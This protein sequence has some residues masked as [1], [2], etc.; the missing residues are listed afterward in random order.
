MTT[1]NSV[2]VVI[3]SKIGT[4]HPTFNG[5]VTGV[6]FIASRTSTPAL[7]DVPQGKV[8]LL[9]LYTR[10]LNVPVVD[11]WGNSIGDLYAGAV[12]TENDVDIGV[13]LTSTSTYPDIVGP[14]IDRDYPLIT[15]RDPNDPVVKTWLTDSPTPLSQGGTSTQNISVKVD[16]FALNPAVVNRTFT[17]TPPNTLVIT[18]P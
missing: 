7:P 8:E 3:P 17:A 9:T 1:T 13:T 10:T 15:F 16:G 18:W 11:K 14:G 5:T 2:T 4:P 12:I 6:N